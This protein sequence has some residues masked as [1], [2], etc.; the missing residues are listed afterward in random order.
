MTM[1]PAN[2]PHSP[3]PGWYA[4]PDGQQQWWDGRQWGP[5]ASPQ[6]YPVAVY[7]A[8]ESSTAYLFAILLGGF[9]AHRF[10]LNSP[11]SAIGFMVLWWGGWLLSGLAV[12]LPMLVAAGIWFVIDLFRIPEM[13]RTANSTPRR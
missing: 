4:N 1:M 2:Q 7:A 9:A 5:V 12:G 8:K 10:Y 13:V 3:P 6:P 11:G